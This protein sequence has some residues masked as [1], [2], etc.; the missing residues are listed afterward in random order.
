[1]KQCDRCS[2]EMTEHT[3]SWYNTQEICFSCRDKEES[4]SDYASCR[5][6]ERQAILRGDFNFSYLPAWKE[7]GHPRA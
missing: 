6:A 2:K 4:R 3:V 1:M 7:S 5:E